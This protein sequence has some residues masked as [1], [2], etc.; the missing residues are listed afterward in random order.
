MTLEWPPQ[1]DPSYVPPSD[2]EY[3]DPELETMPVEERDMLIVA[4]LQRQAAWAYESSP[5]YKK[6]WGE[7]GLW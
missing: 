6:R 5:F 4:K 7:A 1:Y 2:Q 3:W